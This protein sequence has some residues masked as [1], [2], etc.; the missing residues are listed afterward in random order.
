MA[1]HKSRGTATENKLVRL[2][3]KEGWVANRTPASLGTMDV[4]ALKRNQTPRYIQVKGT[5]KPFSTFGPMER[6]DLLA[7]AQK[8]G[9]RAELCWWPPYGQPTFYPPEEWPETFRPKDLTDET[10]SG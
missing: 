3:N 5:Q 7:D 4:I 6:Y 2:L 9:A 1:T 8:A 10:E